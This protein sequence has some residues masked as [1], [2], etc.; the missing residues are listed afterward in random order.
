MH[1]DHLNHSG[2]DDPDK[3]NYNGNGN[4]KD[5]EPARSASR[6]SS[7]RLRLQRDP[8]EYKHAKKGLKKAILEYYR[9]TVLIFFV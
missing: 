6:A 2:R 4:G 3:E 8:E 1:V 7:I 9:L 5:K